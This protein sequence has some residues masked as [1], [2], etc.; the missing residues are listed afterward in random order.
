LAIHMEIV[1]IAVIADGPYFVSGGLPMTRGDGQPFESRSRVT[2][3]RC[4]ES[5]NKPLCDGSQM[6]AGF[7]DPPLSSQPR[8]FDPGCPGPAGSYILSLIETTAAP[9]WN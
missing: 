9:L 7:R 3:C 8:L 1:A 6:Q 2:L 4:G 5:A